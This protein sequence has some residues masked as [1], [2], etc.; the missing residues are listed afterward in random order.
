MPATQFLR[1]TPNGEWRNGEAGEGQG[2]KPHEPRK[3]R[4]GAEGLI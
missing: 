4:H 2:F 3:L 1:G